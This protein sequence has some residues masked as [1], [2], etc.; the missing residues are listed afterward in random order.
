[1]I[2]ATVT[3]GRLTLKIN[4]PDKANALT[5]AM[6]AELADHVEAADQPVLVITG[7]GKVFSAGADLDDVRGGTLATSPE[8]ERLSSAVASFKGLS[9]AS[10]NGSC[11]GGS[12]GM[13]LAC[14]LRVAVETAKF[15]YPV[16]KIGVLPQPSDPARMR[17][18]VGLSATKRILLTGAKIEAQE[19]LSLGL[20]DQISD[21]D[22]EADTLALIEPALKAKPA[23]VS[24]IKALIG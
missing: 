18:L 4:R 12:M 16:I 14:D 13:V 10:L 17:A 9:V 6:L 15:F 8:W 2:E 3:D 23:Q 5:E 22:L 11:A 20:I 19:A 7:E 24:A 1:M 21:L